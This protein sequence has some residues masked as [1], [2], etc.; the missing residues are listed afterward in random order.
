[1]IDDNLKEYLSEQVSSKTLNFKDLIK[2]LE[3]TNFEFKSVSLKGPTALATHKGVFCDID[4]L[5]RLTHSEVFFIL[6][7]EYAHAFRIKKMEVET[8]ISLLSQE[9]FDDVF[10]HV[11]YEELVAD[12]Y[13]KIMFYCFNKTILPNHITQELNEGYRVQHYKE[14]LRRNIGY[15]TIKNSIENYNKLMES[16]IVD[17]L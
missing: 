16:F 14:Y 2:F 6:L 11:L 8:M 17:G 7:H 13:G 10:K 3:E 5:N 15:S 12:R 4:K 9:E 1:M